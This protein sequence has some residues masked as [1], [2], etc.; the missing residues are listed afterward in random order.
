MKRFT[1]TNSAAFNIEANHVLCLCRTLYGLCLIYSRTTDGFDIFHKSM[2]DKDI[3]L[4]CKSMVEGYLGVNINMTGTTIKLTQTGLTK[5]IITA[6]GLNNKYSHS[7][8]TPA[9]CAPLPKDAD[10][11]SASGMI[12]YASILG[13]LLYLSA[14]SR[15]Y[16]SFAVHQSN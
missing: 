7:C 2:Q 15:P 4:C 6:L 5:C 14:N 9:E 10:G 13:M 16:I 3:A 11:E 8:P 12:N 1:C